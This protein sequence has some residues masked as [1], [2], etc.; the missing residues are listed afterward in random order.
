MD[1]NDVSGHIIGAAVEVHKHLGPGLLEAIYR[2]CL[3]HELKL[4]G[5]KVEK[6]VALPVKYKNIEFPAGYRADLL[7]EESVMVELKAVD[8]LSTIHTAQLLSYLRMSGLR[9]GLLINFNVSRLTDGVKRVVNK[10]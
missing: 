2:D 8:A 5:I 1:E 3:T 7:V 6:E 9:L 10:L 4:R